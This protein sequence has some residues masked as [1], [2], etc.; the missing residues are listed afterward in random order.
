MDLLVVGVAL[1]AFLASG[2]ETWQV[3][4]EFGLSLSSCRLI[5]KARRPERQKAPASVRGRWCLNFS[6]SFHVGSR[7]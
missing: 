3:G 6:D 7:V 5:W 1:R 4:M 2:G